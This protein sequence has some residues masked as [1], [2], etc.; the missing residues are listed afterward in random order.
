MNKI[1]FDNKSNKILGVQFSNGRSFQATKSAVASSSY[2]GFIPKSQSIRKIRD[3]VEGRTTREQL[4][5]SLKS[6]S[7]K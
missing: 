2:E 1:K 6:G 3:V 4:I 7:M 5:T